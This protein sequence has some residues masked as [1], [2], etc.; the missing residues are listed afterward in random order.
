MTKVWGNIMNSRTVSSLRNHNA[1]IKHNDTSLSD[2]TSR[3][4]SS[5]SH[6]NSFLNRLLDEESDSDEHEDSDDG[7]S[8]DDS[9]S[10]LSELDTKK[11]SQWYYEVSSSVLCERGL[12]AKGEV[13]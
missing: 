11:E 3:T 7:E 8:L 4:D 5:V 10:A 9:A 1:R 12:A 2:T 13:C 6:A